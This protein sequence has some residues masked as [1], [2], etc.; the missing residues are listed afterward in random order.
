[1]AGH[2]VEEGAAIRRG[3]ARQHGGEAGIIKLLGALVHGAI[4]DQTWTKRHPLLAFT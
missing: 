3:I 4:S 1:L 2:G